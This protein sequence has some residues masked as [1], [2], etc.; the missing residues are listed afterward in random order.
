MDTAQEPFLLNDWLVDPSL[1]CMMRDGVTIKIEGRCVQVLLLLVK[2]AGDIVSIRQIEDEVWGNGLVTQNSIHRAIAQLRRALGDDRKAPSFIETATRRGYRLIAQVRPQTCLSP[3]ANDAEVKLPTVLNPMPPELNGPPQPHCEPELPRSRRLI[4]RWKTGAL[5]SFMLV[6]VVVIFAWDRQEAEQ[7]A[8]EKV[9]AD[10]ISNFML[11][12]FSTERTNAAGM[13]M[14][15]AELIAGRETTA[16]QLTDYAAHRIAIDMQHQPAR[17]AR[18][19]ETIAGSYINADQSERAVAPLEE[20]LTIRRRMGTSAE[21]ATTLTIM[22]SA[23]R[24][25]GRYDDSERTYREALDLL[26]QSGHGETYDEIDLTVQLGLLEIY[27]G[28]P[29]EA[30]RFL[31]DGL[32][33]M[34]KLRGPRHSEVAKVLRSISAVYR[35][36]SNLPRAERALREAISIYALSLPEGHPDRIDGQAELGDLLYMQGHTNEAATVFEGILEPQRRLYGASSIRMARALCRLG[37]IRFEQMHPREGERLMTEAIGILADIGQS[38]DELR[39]FIQGSFAV[40]LLASGHFVR[41]ELLLREAIALHLGST[42]NQGYLAS[43]EHFLGESLL[44]QAKSAE[45]EAPLTQAI[46]RYEKANAPAWYIY[47]S[48][49]ALGEV[50]YRQGKLKQGADLILQSYDKLSND[51]AAPSAAKMRGKRARSLLKRQRAG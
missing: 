38:T 41:S 50:L 17:K 51:P 25:I 16:L 13:Q 33:R 9:R 35:H 10:Q 2:H 8:L 4:R 1:E 46:S 20:A 7:A 24:A 22:G 31:N 12:V 48:K 15:P 47:R 3:A 40:R 23:F 32:A 5:T 27:R 37:E 11:N 26:R 6:F 49:S 34:R 39:A 44:A 30:S 36:G 14:A 19:L 42:N 28:R 21:T 43:S 29:L 45:A 18:M